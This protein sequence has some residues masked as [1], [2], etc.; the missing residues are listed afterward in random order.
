[1]SFI[2]QKNCLIR[3][4]NDINRSQNQMFRMKCK[5]YTLSQKESL[6][7]CLAKEKKE[8]NSSCHK[9]DYIPSFI[10]AGIGR[11][12][13]GKLVTYQ[14]WCGCRLL[15]LNLVENTGID[16][17]VKS[18]CVSSLVLQAFI[19]LLTTSALLLTVNFQFTRHYLIRFQSAHQV[20]PDWVT[21]N[22]LVNWLSKTP[23]W[24]RKNGV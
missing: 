11:L 20:N 7:I 2:I 13:P 21:A 1:M 12:S 5:S 8:E 23:F 19:E 14:I 22:L 16:S 6:K 15:R 24:K 4:L 9:S 17:R 18:F 3:H 10:H